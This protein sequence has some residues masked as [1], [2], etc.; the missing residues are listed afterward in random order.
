MPDFNEKFLYHIWDQQHLISDLLT[1]SDKSLKVC[2]AGHWNR[3]KGPDF[4]NA[5][6]QIN[7]EEMQG[8]IEIHLNSY[9][10][11][12]HNHQDD[13]NYNQV[14]LH[15][16]YENKTN[17]H[18]T[19]KENGEIAE[20]LEIKDLLS[21]DIQKFMESEE[22]A[23]FEEHEKYCPVFSIQNEWIPRILNEYGME[24]FF[25]KIKRFKAELSFCSFDQL[26]YQGIFE[27]LGYS[28]NKFP[29]YQL[30][31]HVPYSRIQQ[32][33]NNNYSKIDILS[34]WLHTSDL[35]NYI[36]AGIKTV[37]S[38]DLNDSFVT[39]NYGIGELS[40]EW[41]LFRLRPIN[42]PVLRLIQILDF[43]YDSAE[44]GLTRH[45]LKLFSFEKEKLSILSFRRRAQMLLSKQ[46]L[47]EFDTR[48]GSSRIDLIL[49]NILI[50][51]IYIYAQKMDYK[52][53]EEYCLFLVREFPGLSENTISLTM[54]K[55]LT[56]D[57]EQYIHTKAISQQGL[58][59]IYQTYCVNHLCE[60]CK[61]HLEEIKNK[62]NEE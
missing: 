26:L 2:F 58:I 28:N 31:T 23:S 57:I 38:R 13:P 34:L 5:V 4:Q 22:I 43:I 30:A 40:Y 60:M 33:I 3:G 11:I 61:K 32:M 12:A 45:V 16:V 37:F 44:T 8:D 50:P 48:I 18:Y 29:F 55:Y 7:G 21:A 27:S 39:H 15:V 24:R 54:K 20:I 19:I 6:I 49:I 36:P 56:E 62:V 1:R 14:I 25:R 17:Q 42:H 10:W 53:L 41:N 52:D 51:I 9:D 46:T 47:K 59:Q 35:I